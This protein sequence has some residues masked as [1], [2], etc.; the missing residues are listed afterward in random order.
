[1]FLGAYGEELKGLELVTP[2]CSPNVRHVYN[3]YSIRTPRRDA[4]AEPLK[5]KCIGYAI[6]YP[7]PLNLQPAFRQ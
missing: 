1:M 2:Y 5:S 4:L 6:H 3:Q 7:L